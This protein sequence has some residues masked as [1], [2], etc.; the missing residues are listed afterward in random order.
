[1]NLSGD[2]LE[3]VPVGKPATFYIEG[4]LDMGDPEVKILAPTKRV[5]PSSIRF[6]GEGHFAVDYTP[7]LVGDHQVEVKM[8]DVQVQNSP[9]I[10]K[11]YDV[12][13]VIVSNVT[14]GSVGKPVYFHIDASQAGAGNL[15]IIVSV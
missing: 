15:E 1:M 12:S 13:K 2:G 5:L 11:A 7:M 3:K 14:G 10:V 4:Q 8:G 6:V 9:F